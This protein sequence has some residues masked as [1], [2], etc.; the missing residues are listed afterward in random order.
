MDLIIAINNNDYELAKDAIARKA[1]INYRDKDM[2][3]IVY[4]MN[5]AHLLYNDRFNICYL[6]IES[7]VDVS[8]RDS[9]NCSLL[10]GAV[11]YGDIRL[12]RFLYEKGLSPFDNSN[13]YKQS[14][15]DI[16]L[17]KHFYDAIILM[18]SHLKQDIRQVYLNYVL[19]KYIQEKNVT[20]VNYVI[21][22]GADAKKPFFNGKSVYDIVSNNLELKDMLQYV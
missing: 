21:G 7:G 8:V 22:L 20:G 2:I 18:T 16:A 14:P 17:K 19:L 11:M 13:E 1:N 12:V 9:K 15:M 4:A 10:Y 5:I 3:L 6:L